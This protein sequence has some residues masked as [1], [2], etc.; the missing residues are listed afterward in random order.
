MWSQSVQN[1]QFTAEQGSLFNILSLTRFT[2]SHNM[3]DSQIGDWV[4]AEL[5]GD[6]VK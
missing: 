5:M 1:V 6:E 2:R 4:R 3:I